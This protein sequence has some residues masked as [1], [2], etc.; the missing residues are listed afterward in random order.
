MAANKMTR[1]LRVSILLLCVCV[2]RAE[3]EAHVTLRVSRDFRTP[4][5]L[6]KGARLSGQSVM[7]LLQCCATV[8]T[9]CGGAFVHSINGMTAGKSRGA[10]RSWFYYVNGLIAGV[11]ATQYIPE[12]GDCVWWDLH[13]YEGAGAVPALIGCFP[14]PFLSFRRP[15]TALPLILHD[16][17]SREKARALA[18]SLERQGVKEVRVQMISDGAIPDDAPSIIIGSWDEIL[19]S[20]AV[21]QIYEHRDTCGVFVEFNSEGLRILALDR[22]PRTCLPRAG[23]ILAARGG[24]A[25]PMPIWLIT[26]T[27][28][29]RTSEAADILIDEPER[30]KGMV[31]AA[32]SGGRLY[33]VPIIDIA[34]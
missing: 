14:Q 21:K 3:G 12:S 1:L 17:R 19:R 10:G 5:L 9:T 4:P 2:V 11:G 13:A 15:R 26:G 8:E 28:H 23:V 32:V 18:L 25:I 33:P 30:I 22:T 7:K 31:S 16:G 6:E 29:E 27:D 24:R 20:S 34:Q